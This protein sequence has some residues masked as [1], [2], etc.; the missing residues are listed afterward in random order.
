MKTE[1]VVI[2][3]KTKGFD[4][5]MQKVEALAEAYDGLPAQLVIK[6]CHDCKI[7]VYPSQ[8]K[9]I[10]NKYKGQKDKEFKPTFGGDYCV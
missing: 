10:T 9:I 5:A 6:N 4:D 3:C 1:E 2:E 8:T 7:N